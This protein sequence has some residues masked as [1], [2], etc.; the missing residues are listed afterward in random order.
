MADAKWAC[1]VGCGLALAAATGCST[2]PDVPSGLV[3]ANQPMEESPYATGTLVWRKPGL[4]PATYTGFIVNPV[5]VYQGPDA[6]YGSGTNAQELANY[7]DRQFRQSLGERYRI[8]NTPGPGTARLQLTLV[9]TSDNV[10]VAATA[11][12]IAPVG[13]VTNVVRTT[14]G[15][16]PTFT[17][18]VT[19]EGQFFDSQTGEPLATFVTTQAP[20]AMDLGATL[21]SQDAQQAAVRVTARD[22]RDALARGQTAAVPPG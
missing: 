6:K 4:N 22:L 16:T 9:G 7:M 17:G 21:T 11:S 1:L 8:T 14:A 10:P 13:I 15:G 19:I 12:R 5:E 20:S 2:T 3:R 18:T